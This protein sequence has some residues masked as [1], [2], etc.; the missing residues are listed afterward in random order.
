MQSQ[1]PPPAKKKVHTRPSP[2]GGRDSAVYVSMKW[3]TRRAAKAGKVGG[4]ATPVR[5]PEER[6]LFV[7][8]MADPSI[9][10]NF[11][12]MAHWWNL[13]ILCEVSDYCRRRR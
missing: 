2:Y 12:K 10:T 13:M 3:M 8:L 11:K 7:K 9:G 5:T 4:P 6:D 1:Q